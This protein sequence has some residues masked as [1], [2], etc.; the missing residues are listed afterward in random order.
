MRAPI[1]LAAVVLGALG[2][3]AAAFAGGVHHMPK[4]SCDYGTRSSIDRT[5][6]FDD[7][8]GEAVQNGGKPP[9]FS[10]NNKVFCLGYVQ[11]YHWNYGTGATPG[12]KAKIIIKRING[13]KVAGIKRFRKAIAL[14]ALASPGQNNVP[15]AN[16]YAY[17]PTSANVFIDGTYR[18]RDTGKKTWS[19]NQQAH[20]F[21]FCH[22]EVY[23]AVKR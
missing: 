13:R 3:A 8:N 16:W 17:T 11:T 10:T 20:G 2:L 9:S 1:E 18:C 22:V 15:N 7:S 12:R 21:G 14:R 4:W 6:L 5:V 19:T 23:P